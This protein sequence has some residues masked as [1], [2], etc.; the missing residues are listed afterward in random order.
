MK[1]G[2]FSVA[3][4]GLNRFYTAFGAI[5]THENSILQYLCANLFIYLKLFFMYNKLL[6]LF[7][8]MVLAS[9]VMAV[10]MEAK[11]KV[12]TIGDSTMANYPTDGST[13]KRGW[14][15]MLQQF[16]NTDNVTVNNR[17]KSGASS[18][19][20]YR[21]SAYWP[22]MVTGGSDAMQAGD[23]LIIQ[24]AHN[25]EKNGGADGDVVKQYYN[26][27]GD[28][29]TASA[30]DY[31]GTT[32]SGTFKEYIRKYIN[33]AKAMGVKPIVVAPICR[34]YFA[35]GGQ[36]IR[37][38][39]KHDLGDNFT[40]CDGTSLSTGN[41]VPESDNT[42]DYVEQA[43]AV[44]YEYDDVPF[45]DLTALTE[46]L[47]LK[48]GE[49]YCT[50]NLFC[51][52]DSTHPS[53]LGATLIAREFAQQ[54]KLQAT[55]ET[56]PKRKQILEELAQDV[57]VSAEI[58][59]NPTSGDM[60]KAYMG[61]SIVKEY[62]VSA[63]GVD[64]G[65]KMNVS[66]DGGFLISNDKVNYNNSLTL[67]ADGN[68]IISSLYV[69]VNLNAP[70]K[71]NGTLTA[72]VGQQT[73]TL[74]LTAEAINLN[75]GTET[76]AVWPLTESTK[77]ND[78][79]LLTLTEQTLS[80]LSVKQYA[81]IGTD[82]PRKMQLL[83][84]TTGEWGVG[85]IDEVSTRY[86]QFKITCPADCNFAIDKISYYISGRG[87]SAVSYHAYYSVNSDFA[88]PVLIDEKVNMAKDAPTIIEC[89]IA[90]QIEEGQSFYVR[91]YPWYNGQTTAA[92]GKYLCISDMNIHGSITKA[93]GQSIDINGSVAYPLVDAQPSFAP[94]EMAVGFVGKT[95]DHG[96]L[97][98]IGQNGGLT[99][100]GTTDN[101]K[102]Q[103][104]VSNVTG[105][106]LP[107][108]AVD[109]NTI[110][111]TLTPED[112]LVFLPSKVTFQAA[113]YGTD[114][115][116]ITASVEANGMAEIC[117]NEG[118]NRSG[119]G[120]ALK[121]ISSEINGVSADAANPLKLKI[122]VLGLGNN[123]SVGLNDIVVEGRLMGQL[124]QTVKYSLTTV[125]TPAG[126]GSVQADPEMDAYK[127]G[128][129]VNLK[130]TRNFGYKFK[131]WQI[132]GNSVS[133]NE[134]FSVKMDGNKI[135]TAV[136]DE[137]P[138][139]TVTAKC[140]NDAE[141]T[142]GNVTLTPNEHDG[143]Y[144]AGT[145]VT[146]VAQESKILKFMQWTDKH[147]NAGTEATR[148]FTVN[149]DMQLV[150][151]YELQDFVAVFDASMTQAYAY[152]NTAN[153]PFTAD[154]A[155]DEQRN[156]T[157]S[158]V[159][160]D[161]GAL[162]Y[163][164]NT[165]T[166]VVRN[167]Q[168]V[169]ISAINGLYQNGYDTREIAWQYQFSTNG[170]TNV[171]IS[172]DMAA[173][174]A[175][176]KK[177]IAKYSLDGINFSDIPGAEWTVTANVLNPISIALPQNAD[178]QP[179]VYVRIM[180]QGDEL[181]STAYSFDNTFDGMAYTSHSESGV[182]NMYVIGVA[183][184]A[185]DNIAPVVISTLPANGDN[186]VS[187]AGRI[188][189]SFDERIQAGNTQNPATLGDKSLQPIW[190]TRSVSFNYNSLKYGQTYSFS[191]P[192][193]YVKDRSGNSSAPVNFSFTVMEK[194]KPQ[195]RIFDAIVDKNLK[196]QQGQ[197]I[198]ATE[199][200]PKQYRFIQDAI[201]D[202]PAN[203]SQ[204]YLIFI[205][206]G[207]YNDPNTTFNSGY[208]TRF[209]TSQ[210]GSGAPTER[211]PGGMNDYDDC[212]LVYVNKPNI[213][214]IGQATDKVTIATDRLDG[215]SSDPNR[216][217]YHVDAGAALEV[218]SAA[219][220]FFM[221][222]VTIDNENW[223]IKRMEGPQALCMNITSDKAVF[224]NIRARSYQDTYKSNGTY[225][226]QFFYNSI[227]EGGVD[228]IY[229]SGDVWFENCTLDIN[230]K[231]GGFI[232]APNHPADTRWGYVFNNTTITTSYSTIPEDYQVYLG[233]PWHDNP[234]TVFLH[235][236]M[237]VKPY[238][239]YWYPT[240]G[241]LPKLW[242]VYD[243]VDRNGYAMSEYSIEDYY[244]TDNGNTI[245]GKAKNYLTDE[246]A[247]M[248]TVANVM[249]GDGSNSEKGIW[250]PLE[251]VEKTEVPMLTMQNNM[252]TW[253][254]DDYAICYVVTVNGK[255][256]AFTTTTEYSAKPGD[257]V[258]VQSVNAHGALS[259]M[260]APVNITTGILSVDNNDDDNGK[261]Y[262][263]MGMPVSSMKHGVFIRNGKKVVVK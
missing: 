131:E 41:K 77:P 199:N 128:S 127:E 5:V 130:A 62:N 102:V 52:D 29:A 188:T 132:D 55:T 42:Y 179:M 122:S 142:M 210:T 92:T 82:N 221:Q 59:F 243:I 69:K 244:Y 25:D 170:F 51:N 161:N 209:T 232:V 2:G 36:S 58:T 140:T 187:A 56:D 93:G 33:E 227:I 174:N 7:R 258:T 196:L 228:F 139:Y 35:T 207:Y 57:V 60:G 28:A 155:W 22:T 144:E 183:E 198:P 124:Q 153:Y 8:V 216:V 186:G 166:P 80:E 39:G 94:E 67:T 44:A 233:R 83:T 260:S 134:S 146:A 246:E 204:P 113:R 256:E 73:S 123:K 12:N 129:I 165:G 103:T 225:N 235:T 137:I 239:G 111:F 218:Q 230:R 53:A 160:T 185:E 45:I 14:A 184:V 136:F 247:A 126:A 27:I 87:G 24:F 181:L 114:G 21:E 118:I 261:T 108:S 112:G 107:T 259:D 96:Q 65:A 34:K 171:T 157:A 223:T 182:G 95:M 76:N 217:W 10:P 262:N 162:L 97:L 214:L 26:S 222:G 61:Q 31:R 115:G 205:K 46:Q 23:F 156:A 109:G 241:G 38:N 164:Q 257:K 81:N 177:Y 98:T 89:N 242:A 121:T 234:I 32:A 100:S 190:N 119:K 167:R 85:E 238:D 172:A 236:K 104:M 66:V 150:A 180:G 101:G 159:R 133:T 220:N 178:N 13:D 251:V 47:Y 64:N 194:Q 15:Q 224:D 229:G 117:N 63:F 249:A 240:M 248:Y 151:D 191:M 86:A 252:V 78:N 90:E 50:L 135:L 84:T 54:L 75:G 106:S 147:E 237:E 219:T 195:L 203:T 48:Y 173:K 105:A 11:K 20:F 4:G 152:N 193:A 43:K 231:K 79:E 149:G 17:G 6:T 16:F 3:T 125:V 37:R 72:T 141:R 176:A 245:T 202:A 254:A 71:V 154:I 1:K 197:S 158:V 68:N 263:I 211:I 74:Q 255:V 163:S 18:K 148:T 49:A 192:E 168:G 175:A 215:A 70:G 120:L 208:G 138:V 250:N 110:T 145:T 226:R 116:N 88:N 200:M 189:I 30:T 143:K 169:V 91:L 253:Q 40:K 213:H 201:D 206:E 9:M 99:W 212:R 19:S